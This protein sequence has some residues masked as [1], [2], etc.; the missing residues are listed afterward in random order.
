M[1][2]QTSTQT[3]KWFFVAVSAVILF[4]FWKVV[5]PFAIV[6]ITAGIVAV[7]VSPLDD[8]L[9]K[10]VKYKK[11]SALLMSIGV[12]LVVLI[13]MFIIGVLV[14]QQ[15]GDVVGWSISQAGWL[16]NFDFTNNVVFLALP[17]V[18][19]EQILAI[20]L[21][22]FGKRVAEV[23]VSVLGGVFLLSFG[24][25]FGIFIFFAALYYFLADKEKI[26]QLALDVSPFKDKLDAKIV[27]RLVDTVRAVV[28]GA[29]TIAIIQA[30]LAG[31]GM[32]IFGVPGA[33]FWG[34]LVAI[35][36][37]VPMVGVSLVMVPAIIYLALT[38]DVG[39][40]VGLTIWSIIFVGLVDNVL[41]PI[42]IGA[43]TQMPEL[44]IL[45][46]ILGG[47]AFFGPIGFIL[48]PTILAAVI[49]IMDLFKEGVLE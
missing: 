34:T 18:V 22:E 46:T 35:A 49:I 40:A 6:L 29:L 24:L 39:S 37:Q 3:A 14:V 27:Q 20:D 13:P 2:K 32:T 7:V 41:T 12:F 30:I 23:M 16:A 8:W 25:V 26:H 21:V 4:L 10:K 45:V 19:Q 38:G 9:R 31:I 17:D 28:F 5:Q 15:A 47:L 42:L 11:L 36:S 48:G 1:N 44:L 43:R 33:L